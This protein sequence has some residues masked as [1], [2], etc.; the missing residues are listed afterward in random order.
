MEIIISRQQSEKE[1]KEVQ[2]KMEFQDQFLKE[3]VIRQKMIKITPFR[4]KLTEKS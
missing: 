3:L 4:K 1:Q 2:R